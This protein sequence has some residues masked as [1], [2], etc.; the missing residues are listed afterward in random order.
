MG[1][2]TQ[3]PGL[4]LRA[5]DATYR[6]YL[7]GKPKRMEREHGGEV[8]R[9]RMGVNMAGPG[10]PEEEHRS[11]TEWVDVRA[12]TKRAMD[13]LEA[14]DKGDQIAVIGTVTRRSYQGEQGKTYTR[15]ITADD[16]RHIADSIDLPEVSAGTEP[17]PPG[18]IPKA[19]DAAYRGYLAD[20]PQTTTRESGEPMVTARMGVSMA[21]A[22]A[23]NDERDE[24]TDWVRILAFSDA[25]RAR[26]IRCRKGDLVVI[27]GN[28]TKRTYHTEG[29]E[30]R[31]ER[32]IVAEHVRA[33][34]ASLMLPTVDSI[35]GEGDAKPAAAG[36]RPPAPIE[37]PPT[38]DTTSA[39]A[40][41][42][43]AVG[44]ASG[45]Q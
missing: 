39:E 20:N 41:A 21:G 24:L 5:C 33:A 7:A 10:V 1:T 37:T 28:V 17:L 14:C 27:S 34:A 30:L 9:A 44:D 8:V 18:A 26:L 42:A 3:R 32:S 13:R 40:A 15:T 38:G 45:A 19:C 36:A 11:L 2:E 29:G 6:G 4:F 31:I 23:S 25:C 35:H 22:G 16:V 12:H 43:A